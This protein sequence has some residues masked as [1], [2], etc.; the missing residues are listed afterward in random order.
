MARPKKCRTVCEI[1]N[2][3]KIGLISSKKGGISLTI[4]EYEAVR[5]IDYLG[6]TQVECALQMDVA[7]STVTAIYLSAR[8]K[9]ANAIVNGSSLNLEDADYE[10]CPQSK[11]CCGACGKNKCGRCNHG[12]CPN[13]IGI[14]RGAKND[15]C[16]VF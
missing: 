5:Q 4:D 7:R 15:S 16:Y 1:P 3:T 2:H 11:T 10:L 13:C 8:K 9:I 14:S 6:L 12:T